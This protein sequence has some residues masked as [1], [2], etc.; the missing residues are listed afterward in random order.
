MILSQLA[1]VEK[2]LLSLPVSVQ[3]GKLNPLIAMD[4]NLLSLYVQ[5]KYSI[6]CEI[7]NFCNSIVL[8]V[9]I[10]C[11]KLHVPVSV[12]KLVAAFTN[13]TTKLIA[14]KNN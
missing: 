9:S 10:V 13:T 3:H 8:L 12:A 4:V 11:L 6:M 7:C 5:L 1:G 2:V 14:K